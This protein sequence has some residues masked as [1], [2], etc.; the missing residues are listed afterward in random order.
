MTYPRPPTCR[1]TGCGQPAVDGDWCEDCLLEIVAARN[2]LTRD[3]SGLFAGS[4][5]A[6]RN[7]PRKLPTL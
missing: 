4:S 1:R 3:A 6:R 2:T 7:Y 5:R